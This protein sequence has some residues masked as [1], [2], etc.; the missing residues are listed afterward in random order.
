MKEKLSVNILIFT[1]LSFILW[2][3][4]AKYNL[5]PNLEN[6]NEL[7]YGVGRAVATTLIALLIAY[8]FSGGYKLINR[9]GI[10]SKVNAFYFSWLVITVLA[11]FGAQLQ[12]ITSHSS[13]TTKQQVAP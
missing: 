11:I 1:T 4:A 10:K 12:P 13:G 8:A 5:F 3:V 9:E 7:A 2:F 6:K